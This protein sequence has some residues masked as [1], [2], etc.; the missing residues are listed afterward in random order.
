LI[1]RPPALI[2]LVTAVAKLGK[3]KPRQHLTPEAMG[4]HER[5]GNAV[6]PGVG[7]YPESAPLV[8]SQGAGLSSRLLDLVITLGGGW[9]A[10][11]LETA[12][13]RQLHPSTMDAA[14]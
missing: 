9:P 5:F 11:P 6:S 8:G 13:S 12:P 2:V 14:A 1:G 4:E 3:H 7:K 10:S